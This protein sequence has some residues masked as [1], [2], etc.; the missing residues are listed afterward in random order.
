[1]VMLNVYHHDPLLTFF[2]HKKK[3]DLESNRL[4]GLPISGG[5]SFSFDKAFVRAKSRKHGGAK[6]FAMA[7]VAVGSLFWCVDKKRR[8][9]KNAVILLPESVFV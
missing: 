6:I 2:S 7:L 1:M 4:A 5:R 9:K 3:L 8:K